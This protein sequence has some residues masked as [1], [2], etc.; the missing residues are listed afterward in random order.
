MSGVTFAQSRHHHRA[1]HSGRVLPPPVI[2]P[3]GV[4]GLNMVASAAL[5]STAVFV[6]LGLLSVLFAVTFGGAALTL[7]LLAIHLCVTPPGTD[8]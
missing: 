2:G 4:V 6:G 3:L 5:G 7:A 8:A 1:P